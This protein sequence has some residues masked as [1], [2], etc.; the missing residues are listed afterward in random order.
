MAKIK[1]IIYRSK[2]LAND[3][4]PVAIRITKI[5]KRKYIFLGYSCIP[6]QWNEKEGRFKSN[7]PN[8]KKLN[9]VLAK[10]EAQ[11]RE[12]LIEFDD[13]G[14]NFTLDEVEHRFLGKVK[15]ITVFEYFDQRINELNKAGKFGNANFYRD[16]KNALSKFW[17]DEE[18]TF[19][20]ANYQFLK[21]FESHMY[22]SGRKGNTPFIYMRTFRA[23]INHAIKEGYCK[24]K[25]YPFKNKLNPNGYDVEH[26]KENTMKRAISKEKI[27][28]IRD[29]NAS[30]Y[31]EL[32]DAKNYFLFS[33]YCRGMNI[34]DIAFLRWPD[35]RNGRVNYIRKK[36]GKHYSVGL[37]DEAT[38]I[39]DQYRSR[40]SEY[41]FPIL[42]E[43][44]IDKEKQHRKLK[45]KIGTINDQLN[46]I[47]KL[48]N[49]D[50]ILTTYVARHSWATILKKAGVSTSIISEGLGHETEKTTQD[51]LDSFENSV[52][53]EA[54]KL[55]L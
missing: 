3:E 51:Y 55:I 36:T 20:S 45:E 43:T 19:D 32:K 22:A 38:A 24:T 37:L 14:R 28:L 42:D 16:T 33:F 53:D 13:E 9:L 1:I 23:L 6:K 21:K 29:F 35:I 39:I 26:L 40:R 12:V 46:R 41:V 48:L 52:L 49:L 44:I 11:I 15:S 25:I 47:S 8:Y 2:K 7:Y 31:P 17:E 5:K 10:K 54:N 50:E 34:S 4:H 27:R 18:L 30:E